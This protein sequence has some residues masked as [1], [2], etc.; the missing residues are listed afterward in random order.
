[1]SISLP[2]LITMILGPSV[3]TLADIIVDSFTD[4]VSDVECSTL[5]TELDS[6]ELFSFAVRAGL[7]NVLSRFSCRQIP[8]QSNLSALFE[9]VAHYEF[10]AKPAAALA[11]IHSGIPQTHKLFWEW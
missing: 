2:S 7:I 9:Q 6:N 3:P 8:T 4:Y 10:C 5:K 1:M 11:L